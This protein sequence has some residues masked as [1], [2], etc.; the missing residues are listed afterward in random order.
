M[1]NLLPDENAP[2]LNGLVA[3]FITGGVAQLRDFTRGDE[4]V[5]VQVRTVKKSSN[6]E[7]AYDDTYVTGDTIFLGIG[8]A[9]SNLALAELTT[10]LSAAA[11]T[12]TLTVTGGTNANQTYSI[13]FTDGTYA[14]RY[15]ITATISATAEFCGYAEPLMSPAELRDV[16]LNHSLITTDNISVETDGDS[17][18]VTFIGN[19]SGLPTPTFTVSNLSLVAPTGVS[20]TFIVNTDEMIAAFAATTANWLDLP[21]EIVRL[22]S[23]KMSAVYNGTVRVYRS[24]I[25]PSGAIPIPIS[26]LDAYIAARAVCY[27]RAQTLTAAQKLQAVTNQ[28]LSLGAS[29][30]LGEASSG[31]T[32]LPVGITLGTGLTM[33]GTTLSAPDVGSVTSVGLSLPNIFTVSGSPVTTTGT[34]TAVF[35]TQSANRVFAGPTTGSAAAPAFRA[36]VAADI[37]GLVTP[38]DWGNIT[39]TLSD[40]TDLQAALDEKI[41]GLVNNVTPVSGAAELDLLTTN[42]TVLQTVTPGAGVFAALAQGANDPNG[43]LVLE[44]GGGI[45]ASLLPSTTVFNG[46]T[47]SNA[48]GNS[49]QLTRGTGQLIVTG[50]LG[51]TGLNV[52]GVAFGDIAS[53]NSAEYSPVAGSSSIATVGTVT[54]GTWSAT[55]IAAN[56]GGTGQTVYAVGDLLYASTTTALS[57]LADVATGSVLISGGVGVAPSWGATSGITAG[58]ASAVTVA[59]EAT[60]TT[61]FIHFGTAATGNLPVKSNAGLTF[62]S[63]TGTLTAGALTSSGTITGFATLALGT[64]GVANAGILMY[65]NGAGSYISISPPAGSLGG[66]TNTLQDV[67]D[68]FV[69]RNS[70]DTLTNKSIVATQLT[71]TIADAR[72]S[73]NVPLLNA[74]NTFT[75]EN[76]NSKAGAASVTA[77]KF[78]G[79]P[80]AGTGTTSF[81]LVYLNDATATASTTLS[82]S[83]TYLGVNGHGSSDLAN[84]M[85]DGTSKFKVQS[86][87]ATTALQ[88]TCGSSSFADSVLTLGG[89]GTCQIRTDNNGVLKIGNN[90]FASF[91]RLV[92]GPNTTSG[93]AF[94]V[95]TTG[96]TACLGDGSAGGS[97]TASGT[98]T[99]TGLSTLTGGILGTVAGGNAT[100]GNVGEYVSAS[101]VQGSA[102]ALT[103]ATPK[104]VT[105]ITLT[106][107]DWDITAIGS[108]TGASTGTAFDVAIGTTTN[109]FTGT[110]LGDTRCETPTVSLTGADA[111]LM[112]PAVRVSISGSTTYYL[113]VQEVFTIGTPAAYGRISARRVR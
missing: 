82:T 5:P 81:P 24:V 87:G 107:G 109:S 93:A 73:A 91:T 71:G 26:M 41:S 70:T 106:A 85:L 111:T 31:G 63:S 2:N 89:A 27:D 79:V 47:F 105:S 22:R 54:T 66:S 38:P 17:F 23:S 4:S 88:L 40:Q 86:N 80:F 3:N 113:V 28:G 61:C 97:F 64:S 30:L 95:S 74:A 12:R 68:T 67:T 42:G 83:G 57:K 110:V 33:S 76:T 84:L 1:W 9:P 6:S 104:T 7:H 45:P 10:A 59:N 78:T 36:L 60:D 20:G 56:K 19:L 112:I 103:T 14:G 25:D 18:I 15:G 58:V 69:Y 35:A 102:T 96:I 53:H 49:F 29:Q 34:L 62:D 51:V 52:D 94:A 48:S 77:M 55:A 99:A 72:L 21:F 39:G 90:T 43:I 50:G 11:V 8:Y 65:N 101:V 92:M 46:V 13:S 75:A 44:A 16:F 100:A 98:L 32:G 37:S 108:I